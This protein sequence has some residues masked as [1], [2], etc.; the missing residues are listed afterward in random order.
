MVFLAALFGAIW[1]LYSKSWKNG[2]SD[3]LILFII[4]GTIFLAVLGGKVL[5]LVVHFNEFNA[6]GGLYSGGTIQAGAWVFGGLALAV[7]LKYFVGEV[8]L[9]ARDMGISVF[10]AIA[11]GRMGCLLVGDDFGVPST[12]PWAVSYPWPLPVGSMFPAEWARDNVCVHPTQVY[13]SLWSLLAV[14][15]IWSKGEQIVNGRLSWM[16]ML[17]YYC[18]GR[19]FIGLTRGDTSVDG[20]AELWGHYFSYTQLCCAILC[21]ILPIMIYKKIPTE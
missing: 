10:G 12:L 2:L 16:W 1:M 17:I 5:F 6:K 11:I 3:F 4:T 19:L 15:L 13:Y 14:F 18:I 21:F 20:G 7:V 9:F 8:S